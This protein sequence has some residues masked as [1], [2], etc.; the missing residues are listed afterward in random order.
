MAAGSP[1]WARATGPVRIRLPLPAA[2]SGRRA[3]YAAAAVAIEPA[4]VS[5]TALV[6]P[7]TSVGPLANHAREPPSIWPRS[8]IPPASGVSTAAAIWVS[9][10]HSPGAQPNIPPPVI[11][12][13]ADAAS[14]PPNS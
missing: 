9:S 11:E 4:G 5:S 10:V 14:G 6:C 2:R 12:T 3:V 8:A 1:G 7:P 13:G